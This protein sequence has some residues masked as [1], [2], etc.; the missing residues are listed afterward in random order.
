[1]LPSARNCAATASGRRWQTDLLQEHPLTG[2]IWDVAAQRF[3]SRDSLA[4]N[5]RRAHFRLLGEVHDNPDHH[6]IQAELLDA[7][8]A[9]GV[10]PLVAF[11]QFD[12]EYDAALQQLQYAGKITADDVARTVK[13]DRKGWDWNY[14]RPLV[15]IALRYGMPMR[16]ANLSRAAAGQIVKRFGAEGGSADNITA[17]WTAEKEQAMRTS[18][19]EGHCG[20]LPDSMVPAMTAAQRARDTALAETLLDAG[21]DGAVLIAGNGHARRDLAV[22]VYLH[23]ASATRICAIGILEVETASNEPQDYVRSTAGVP[24]FDFVYF[25]PP[26]PRPDP[27]AGFKS[28]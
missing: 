14:Y 19:I 22:P 3:I 20:A 24:P 10:R 13:F 2:T 21:S 9:G 18:I 7:I 15:E 4:E 16:A 23:A 1:M 12:R 17:P 6:A 25:T 5:A 26:R 28:G 8:G 11:E 27:C